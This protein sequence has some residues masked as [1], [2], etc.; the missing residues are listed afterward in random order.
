MDAGSKTFVIHVVIWKQEEMAMDPDRKTQIKAQSRVQSRAQGGAQVRALIF[1]KAPT[2]VP[3]EYS[4]YNNVFSAENIV[5]LPE[6]TGVNDH[7]IKLEEGKQPP[8]RPIYNLGQVELEALKIYI[9]TNLA[10]SFIQSFKS[11]AGTP[12]FFN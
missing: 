6:N 3:A 8:F 11:P 9:K 5:E 10:N 1:N 7:A 12:I 4:D 2:E